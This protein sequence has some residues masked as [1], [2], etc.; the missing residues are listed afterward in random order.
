MPV[1]DD[2]DLTNPT[3]AQE[4]ALTIPA[5]LIEGNYSHFFETSPIGQPDFS[6][7]NVY[8]TGEKRAMSDIRLFRIYTDPM[9]LFQSNA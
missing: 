8:S 1:P 2:F 9:L 3:E 4:W 5:N 7:E 6:R